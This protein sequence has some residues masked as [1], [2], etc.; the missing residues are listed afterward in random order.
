MLTS[1]YKDAISSLAQ[2]DIPT[3]IKNFSL[4]S[5]TFFS[6]SHFEPISIESQSARLQLTQA[7]DNPAAMIFYFIICG[8]LEK[9]V[10]VIGGRNPRA[11]FSEKVVDDK[12]VVMFDIHWD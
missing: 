7:T 1:T 10:E 4:I 11:S 6:H 12:K 5:K 8:A 3:A 9:L 2:E